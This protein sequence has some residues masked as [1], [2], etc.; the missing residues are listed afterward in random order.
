MAAHATLSR[1]PSSIGPVCPCERLSLKLGPDTIAI[2]FCVL[3][4]YEII[5]ALTD[6]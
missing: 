5:G 6:A 4:I 1:P 2:I 3:M